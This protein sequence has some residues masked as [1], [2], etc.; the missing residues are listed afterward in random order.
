MLDFSEKEKHLDFPAR[1]ISHAEKKE[2]EKNAERRKK[3][4]KKG[5]LNTKAG[6]WW[7]G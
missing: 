1:N 6:R 2:K 5:K 7:G 4:R 3:E